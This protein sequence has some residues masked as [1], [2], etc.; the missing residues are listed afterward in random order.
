VRFFRL[1][2]Q[3]GTILYLAGVLES[4]LRV[5]DPP[6]P[7]RNREG[8]QLIRGAP[9]EAG[10]TQAVPKFTVTC[11]LLFRVL[12]LAMTMT[13]SHRNRSSRRNPRLSQERILEAA[14]A[15]FA[16][17]GFAGARVDRIAR[18]ARINKRMLYHYF[19]AKE[20]LFRA[21]LRRKMEQRS[22]WLASAPEDI[23]ER[24]PFWFEL[25][26][27]DREWIRLL[28]WEALQWGE[29]RVLDEDCRGESFRQALDRLRQMQTRGQLASG[30]AAAQLML[31]MMALTAYPLA[32]PQLTRLVTG[33]EASDPEFQRQRAEFLRTFALAFQGSCP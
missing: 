4:I 18:R 29:S 6:L 1:L 33:L 22:A 28:E 16:A 26:C 15:E 25:A 31:S 17:Q 12:V 30:F 27:R 10:L 8:R 21:V 3:W 23:T 7:S 2:N 20:E 13:R 24:L 14:L 5:R 11:Q 32:F 9:P 19:G